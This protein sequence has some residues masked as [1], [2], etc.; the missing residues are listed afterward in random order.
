MKEIEYDY[1]PVHL[2]RDGGEQYSE[3]FTKINPKQEVPVLFIDG[4]KLVQ[5]VSIKKNIELK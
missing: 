1:K 3:E 4:K 2:V 5:S